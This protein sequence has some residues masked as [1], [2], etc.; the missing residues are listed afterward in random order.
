MRFVAVAVDYDGTIAHDGTVDPKTVEALHAVRASGRKLIL[1][2]GRYLPDLLNTFPRVE[3]FDRVVA[4]NGALLYR[5]G[6]HEDKPL[7]KPIPEKLIH[8]LERRGVSPLAVGEASVATWQPH[9]NTVLL[10]IKDLGLDLHVAFNKGAVMIL[11]TGVHKGTG[12]QKALEEL[13]LSAHNVVGFGDA[14]N[15]YAFLRLCECSVAVANALESIKQLA[16][17]VTRGAHGDGVIEVIEQ[18]LADD[19][20]DY[21]KAVSRHNILLGTRNT[22]ASVTFPPFDTGVLIAGPSG[23]GK[24]TAAV[25]ILERL[26]E[27]GYQYCLFDPEADFSEMTSA[28]V[29]GT[30]DKEPTADEAMQ[31]LAD[32]GKSVALN[33]IAL[34]VGDRPQFLA[35][36]FPRLQDL[37]LK[38]GRPHWI[39]MDKAHHFLP[40]AREHSLPDLSLASERLMITVDP[41]HVAPGALAGVRMVVAPGEYPERTI[42]S[43]LQSVGEPGDAILPFTLD[44]GEALVWLRDSPHEPI[45][46]KIEPGKSTTRRHR[47]K[48]AQGQLGPDHSFYFRGPKT[49]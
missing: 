21:M 46:C 40:A 11:P 44:R 13:A 41:A 3:I 16:D 17:L 18:L 36:L 28:V 48:Y 35:S 22:G 10:A 43:F 37:W 20:R 25:G 33:L 23:G 34:S 14:E 26:A 8:E 30:S 32:P 1:V 12:L 47:E 38:T 39:V 4:E 42:C 24:S 15:D 2:T 45:V 31:V 6:T 49:S 27:S 5:P 19:L 29:L 7:S 9:E